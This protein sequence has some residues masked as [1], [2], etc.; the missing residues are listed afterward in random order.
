MKRSDVN[1][2]HKKEPLLRGSFLFPV[3]QIV[4]E[5]MDRYS[6]KW[7]KYFRYPYIRAAQT[8]E[9]VKIK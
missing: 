4:V 7:N 8:P 1:T 3:V 6:F 5:K 9:F 2:I